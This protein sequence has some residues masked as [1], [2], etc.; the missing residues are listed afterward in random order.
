MNDHSGR[1]LGNYLLIRKLGQGGFGEVYLAEHVHLKTLAAI[2]MLQHV[3]LPSNEEEKFREEAQTIA[4]LDHPHIIR[5]LDYGIQ[6]STSTPY[7][8]MDYAPNGTVRQRYPRGKILEPL[9]ILSY[10]IQVADALQYAH[11]RKVIHRD[12]KPENMLLNKQNHIRLSDFGIAVVYETTSSPNTVD[13]LGTPSY[14][15]PEQFRGKP[16]Y[17]SDQY[18][19]GVVVYEWLCGTLPFNG[20]IGELMHQHE[21]DL[22]PSMSDKV[23]FLSPAIEVVVQKLLP[24]IQRSGMQVSRTLLRRFKRHA[25]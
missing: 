5:V 25:R 15:A 6:E 11:D 24:R 2:K 1:K 22:P 10:V 19:L 8:V 3:Q 12:V 18:S 17:A 20:T 21:H 14:M 13:K 23:V 7:L 9:H 4:K 16:L